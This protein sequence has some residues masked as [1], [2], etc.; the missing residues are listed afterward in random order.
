MAAKKPYGRLFCL[1]VAP[2]ENLENSS[3]VLYFRGW[4]TVEDVLNA[5]KEVCA[6]RGTRPSR[7]KLLE[8]LREDWSSRVPG[9]AP[10]FTKKQGLAVTIQED[11]VFWTNLKPKKER[12][13]L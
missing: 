1:K 9:S 8:T 12:G 13:E 4:P 2:G 7:A 10:A 5:V 11:K 3:A 6:S